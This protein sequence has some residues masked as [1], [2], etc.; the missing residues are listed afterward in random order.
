MD[1]KKITEYV[2]KIGSSKS[3]Q[4]ESS[5]CAVLSLSAAFEIS[6]DRAH[7]F[8]EVK[9]GRKK[10][11]GTITRNII[12][13]MNEVTAVTPL[14]SKRAQT[15]PVINEYPTKKGV[16]KCKSKLGTFANKNPKG[17]Y[18]VL[19]REHAT[20]VKDGIILDNYAPGST[21]KFAWKIN[22]AM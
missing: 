18:F 20:V 22:D 10:K 13:T 19:V 5:D 15:A 21:V 4:G 6:Y 2:S 17:T 16:V 1:K 11:Q 3:M 8:A 12:N 9:W 7:K 14:F